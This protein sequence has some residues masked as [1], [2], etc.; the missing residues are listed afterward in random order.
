MSGNTWDIVRAKGLEDYFLSIWIDCPDE[1]AVAR[2]LGAKA[3]SRSDFSSAMQGYPFGSGDEPEETLWV[4]RHG[5]HW[6]HVLQISGNYAAYPTLHSSLTRGGGRLLF[7]CVTE[8]EGIEDL[9]LVENARRTDD[10]HAF[11]H[12]PA[13]PDGL[14][15]RNM[16]GLSFEGRPGTQEDA[17]LTIIGRIT[18]T[19]LT[20]EWFDRSHLLCRVP[21]GIW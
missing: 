8:V 17:Y 19:P 7:M 5:P 11:N 14:F 15:A 18:G 3:I 1:E 10:I 9:V 6:T 16:A 2:R 13:Q 20:E 12:T 21:L 4:G